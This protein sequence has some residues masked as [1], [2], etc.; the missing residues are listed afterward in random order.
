MS[1]RADL[2]PAGA[3][4][5]ENSSI[6]HVNTPILAGPRNSRTPPGAQNAIG[7]ELCE[8][9]LELEIRIVDIGVAL[10][11][12]LEF[13]AMKAQAGVMFLKNMVVI[14]GRAVLGDN[15]FAGLRGLLCFFGRLGHNFP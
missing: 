14:G 11:K 4:I 5:K 9:G 3:C 7:S 8:G 6:L 10:A 13:G 15:L 12:S 2:S 1:S